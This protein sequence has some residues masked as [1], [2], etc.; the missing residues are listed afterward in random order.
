MAVRGKS[1]DSKF[2]LVEGDIGRAIK[3]SSAQIAR[4]ERARSRSCLRSSIVTAMFLAL[5]AVGVGHHAGGSF[6]RWSQD[7]A[8]SWRTAH[9]PEPLPSGE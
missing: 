5:R 7:I 4:D 6:F 9:A 3:I 1:T 2:V 8:R